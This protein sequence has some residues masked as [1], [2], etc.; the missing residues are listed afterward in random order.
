METKNTGYLYCLT[1]PMYAFYGNDVYKLGRSG[2]VSKRLNQYSTS[3]VDPPTIKYKSKKLR[4]C[5][6]AEKLLFQYLD[7]F[8]MRNN[9]EFFKLEFQTV[10]DTIIRVQNEIIDNED[11]LFEV[12]KNLLSTQKEIMII[13]T[14][15][16]KIKKIYEE[17]SM[18]EML[19][20]YNFYHCRKCD[21]NFTRK[22]TLEYHIKNN[23]CKYNQK[24][25]CTYCCKLFTTT[26]SMERHV[27]TMCKNKI[28]IYER[29]EMCEKIM[30]L[31]KET[32]ELQCNPDFQCT[33]CAKKFT[34]KDT[35]ECHIKN[36]SC[37][38][39][40]KIHCIHCYKVYTSVQ[41]MERH[42]RHTCEGKINISDK[43]ALE[44]KIIEL[45]KG[46]FELTKKTIIVKKKSHNIHMPGSKRK[47]VRVRKNK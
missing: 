38:F 1:N 3:Y 41:S 16:K 31:H 18:N 27:L 5:I 44:E 42:I 14:F 34:R 19:I 28:D 12:N 25:K 17:P 39:A 11:K 37:I 20:D 35:L 46:I 33:K 15:V 45:Q 29:Q 2:D 4:N 30:E 9:R 23:S 10:K 40:P 43:R 7:D 8:R 22:D 21:K 36:N 24:I 6:I 32:S 26:Q 47:N 13:N